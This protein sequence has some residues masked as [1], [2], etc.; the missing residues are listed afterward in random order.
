MVSIG[1]LDLS[2]VCGMVSIG[3]LDLSQVCG[4]VSIG[5]LDLSQVCLVW[6]PLGAKSECIGCKGFTPLDTEVNGYLVGN[7]HELVVTHTD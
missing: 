5:T 4:M 1:T 6:F 3:T 2:Q 7:V